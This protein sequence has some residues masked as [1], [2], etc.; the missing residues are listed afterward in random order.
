MHNSG[1]PCQAAGATLLILPAGA[2]GPLTVNGT[3]GPWVCRERELPDGK[4]LTKCSHGR[5]F[6]TYER[7]S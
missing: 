2:D 5:R 4:A 1:I 7:Q 3:G 6:F